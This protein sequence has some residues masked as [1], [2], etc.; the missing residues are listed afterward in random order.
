MTDINLNA[1]Y[2]DGMSGVG[3][4]LSCGNEWMKSCDNSPDK[5]KKDGKII[6]YNN[7]GFAPYVYE[8]IV[9]KKL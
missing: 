5:I 3:F 4:W 1:I 2:I 8:I 7:W 6:K 9:N